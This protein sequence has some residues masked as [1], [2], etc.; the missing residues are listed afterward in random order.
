MKDKFFVPDNYVPV[1]EFFSSGAE[2][3]IPL[4]LLD[5]VRDRQ[6]QI[7]IAYCDG[8]KTVLL[9]PDR[10]DLEQGTVGVNSKNHGV[11]TVVMENFLNDLPVVTHWDAQRNNH[12]GG[13]CQGAAGGVGTL[14]IDLESG[15]VK[16]DKPIYDQDLSSPYTFLSDRYMLFSNREDGGNIRV[17]G[18]E[19]YIGENYSLFQV[20]DALAL[21]LSDK[22]LKETGY[23][24]LYKNYP[25]FILQENIPAFQIVSNYI[26][27]WNQETPSLATFILPPYWRAGSQKRYP[28]LFSGFYDNNENMFQTIGPSFLNILGNLLRETGE[29]VIGILWNG[30]GSIGARTFQHSAYHNLS[31]LFR[32]AAQEYFGDPESIVAVGGSRGGI[33]AL[34]AAANSYHENYKI[35]YAVCYNPIVRFGESEWEIPNPTCPLVY[36]AITE[37]T[38]YKLAWMRNWREPVSGLTGEALFLNNLFG[39]CDRSIAN[40]VLCP[41][42]RQF[43]KAIGEKGTKV[44]LAVGTHD[45][46]ATKDGIIDFAELLRSHGVQVH[47]Q[48]GYRFGHN[49][50]TNLYD[51]AEG[52]LKDILLGKE[53]KLS[54]VSH[55]RRSCRDAAAWEKSELFS[56]EHQPVFF[57]GPKKAALGDRAIINIVGEAGMAYVLKLYKIDAVAWQDQKQTITHDEGRVLFKGVLEKKTQHLNDISYFKS[58]IEFGRSY[59][60]GFYLYE[61]CY[62]HG[63]TREW[64]K[65]PPENVPQPGIDAY[66][67]LEII[68]HYPAVSGIEMARMQ[69]VK[70][71]GWGLSEE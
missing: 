15:M 68:N 61:L 56:P 23:P 51:T 52:F 70:A 48:F 57:E 18:Y 36:S 53:K 29:P 27:A 19:R 7:R 50:A 26:V 3:H 24:I 5:F 42:S 35:K 43:A 34:V 66:P 9:K 14:D 16:N 49:N 1:S 63:D 33:T 46:F 17:P 39:T 60:E 21:W 12:R 38:G 28:V 13:F 22:A 6:A 44:F 55:Y 58:M 20:T 2:L 30:G 11:F 8:C 71:I 47:L 59:V 41:A 67:V 37:D 65:I 4:T 54:G 25:D 10:L 62:S 40:E 69:D 31:E 32:I 64:V 45:A